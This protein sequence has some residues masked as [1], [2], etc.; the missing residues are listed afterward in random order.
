MGKTETIDFTKGPNDFFEILA[1]TTIQNYDPV[2]GAEFTINKETDAPTISSK[3]YIFFG[4]VSVVTRACYGQG[5][6]SSIVLQSADLDEIDWEWLGG[7]RT[8]VQTNYFGKGDTTT[9]DRGAYHKVDNPQDKFYNYTIDWTPEFVAWYIDGAKV[10]QLNYNDAKG[11]STFPQTPCQLKLGNWVAGRQ[12]AAK[13]TVDW[14]GGYTDFSQAPFHAYY[15]SITVTDYHKGAVKYVWPEVASGQKG[16]GSYKGITV[17]NEGGETSTPSTSASSPSTTVV[18]S[19]K[20]GDSTKTTLSTTV[21]GSTTRGLTQATDGSDVD[22][23]SSSIPF[24]VSSSTGARTSTTAAPS[25][26]A[27]A[28]PASGA[29]RQGLEWSHAA[30][31]GASILLGFLVM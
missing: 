10:R 1:G 4:T 28:P 2:L 8:Q 3:K 19:T 29:F 24:T 20:S 14:A 6:V 17:V 25:S 5:V 31:M 9:Y 16:D 21:T 26:T 22:H 23:A 12:G 30:V 11:G 18:S 15:K 7:D 27:S 13:G